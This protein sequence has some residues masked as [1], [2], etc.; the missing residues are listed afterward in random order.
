ML[1]ELAK[2]IGGPFIGA[3]LAFWSTRLHDAHR[4]RRESTAAGNLALSE[5]NS[6]HNEFLSWRAGVYEEFSS[7]DRSADSPIWAMMRPSHQSFGD[8]TID[9]KSLAFLFE[10]PSAA[11]ALNAMRLAE[12]RFR[13]M[14]SI[15]KFRNDAAV[16]VLDELSKENFPSFREAEAALGPHRI[17][18]MKAAVTS[19]AQR[20][21]DDEPDYI[22][23]STKLRAALEKRLA[24]RW[25]R[26]PQLV[27]THSVAP[28]FRQENLAPF[29]EAIVNLL[30]ALDVRRAEDMAVDRG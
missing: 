13:D 23:A 17:A 11:E 9:I 5:L 14:V 30:A 12:M 6:M 27:P 28:R 10:D 8:F 26:A 21:R 3:G 20:V 16:A 25:G 19:V 18:T 4:R 29:P 22:I 15:H 7:P 2:A 1:V 24:R